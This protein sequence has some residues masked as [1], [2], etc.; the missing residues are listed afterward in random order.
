MGRKRGKSPVVKVELIGDKEL[1]RKL[2]ALGEFAR[3]VLDDAAMAGAKVIQR[4]A[5]RRA[6]GP[7]VKIQEA[8]IRDDSVWVDIGPDE[9]HWYYRFFELGAASHVI[10]P[11]RA[12]ALHL[13]DLDVFAARAKHPGM[14]ARPFLRPAVDEKKGEAVKA[15]RK[16]LKRAVEKAADL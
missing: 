11:S 9:E 13:Y 10:K 16:V 15:A 5:N 12:K 2:R 4:E 8:E 3:K 1:V 14:A 7:H 6:P